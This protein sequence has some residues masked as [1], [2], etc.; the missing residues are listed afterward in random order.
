MI[1]EISFLSPEDKKVLELCREAKLSVSGVKYSRGHDGDCMEAN[2]K[3][4]SRIKGHVWDD[5]WG[6]DFDYQGAEVGQFLTRLEEVIAK[7]PTYKFRD[8]EMTYNADIVV[9]LLV[10]QAEDMKSCKKKIIVSGCKIPVEENGLVQSF[11]YNVAYDPKHDGKIKQDMI[12]EGFVQYE[13]INKRF[14]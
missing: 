2:L 6:G 3:V 10:K 1:K 4:G 14:I 8:M 5:S 9:D 12:N 11:Q 13:I 7:A